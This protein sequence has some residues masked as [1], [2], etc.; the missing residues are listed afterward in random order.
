MRSKLE[1]LKIT[2]RLLEGSCWC[3]KYT[4]LPHTAD[5]GAGAPALRAAVG[6]ANRACCQCLRRQRAQGGFAFFNVWKHQKREYF[7][8]HEN[9]MQFEFEEA[10]LE[11]GRAHSRA[12]HLRLPPNYWGPRESGEASRIY[13]LAL[14]GGLLTPF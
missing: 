9:D 5:L 13:P 2:S 10:V 1:L 7:M 12:Y 11:R 14:Y 6:A 3:W 8:S 4:C